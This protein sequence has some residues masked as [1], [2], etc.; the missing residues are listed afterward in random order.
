[1]SL[2]VSSKSSGTSSQPTPGLTPGICVGI[3]DLG[4]QKDF[5][6]KEVTPKYKE[7][8]ALIF[9]LPDHTY[10]D[11]EEQTH[12]MR[13][14]KTYTQSLYDGSGEGS[15]A[16]LHRDLCAWRGKRFTEEEVRGFKLTN[17]LG[18]P[19]MINLKEN[20][21]GKV[22]ISGLM[23][24]IGEVGKP[25]TPPWAFDLSEPAKN[26]DKLPSFLQDDIRLCQGFDLIEPMLPSAAADT[27]VPF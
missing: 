5:F 21:N 1:M 3:A 20:K 19:C 12:P 10:T 8:V 27:V 17:V 18:V 2:T 4:F 14:T 25:S 7:K 15:E 6:N 23:A 9:E 22:G 11:K 26:W 16:A 13:M 24:A